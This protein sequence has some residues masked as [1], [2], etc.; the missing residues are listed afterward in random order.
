MKQLFVFFFVFKSVILFT[1]S[2]QPKTEGVIVS[3]N[4]LNLARWTHRYT[5]ERNQ[6]IVN[7]K[8][9]KTDDYLTVIETGND[10]DFYQ[11]CLK[12]PEVKAASLN[13]IL[14]NRIKPNDQRLN[15]LYHH[16]V[17]RSFEAWDITTGGQNHDKKDIVIGIV[18]DGFVT[19]HED[20]K[21]NLYANP[22][23]IAGDGKDN[24]GNGYT[25]DFNGWNQRTG[26]G[27]HDIMSHGTNILGVLGAKGN[28]GKGIVGMN[29]DTKLLPVT[30]N[31]RVSDIIECYNY[32]LAEKKL[33]NATQG[34]KGSNI[35]VVTYSGGLPNAFAKDHPIWCG[36]YDKLGLEG[37]LSVASTTN[38][39]VNVEEDGDM[40]S[41]CTSPYLLIVNSADKSDQMDKVTG[42]GAVS[43][44]LAAPGES[45]LSTDQKSK[46]LYKTESGTSLSTPMVAGAAALIYSLKCKDF[47]DLVTN[48]RVEAVLAVKQAIIDGVDT[49]ISLAGKTTSGGR[50]NVF[51]AMNNIL[52]KYCG[53]AVAPKGDLE[54]TQ[55]RVFGN[56]VSI[57]YVTPDN[58]EYILKLYDSQGREIH[59]ES[60][61]PPVLGEKVLRVNALLQVDIP[62]IASIFSGKNVASKTF[63]LVKE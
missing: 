51:N 29:W 25:D 36:L 46:N 38:D 12:Q 8:R 39:A 13:Y 56:Q 23:E 59:S 47:N 48:S 20:L 17:I 26:N 32:F 3:T 7:V 54:I 4:D 37:I 24:D 22:D 40:P 19:D 10:L 55:V 11:W 14:E 1:Q 27:V 57:N 62:Y 6:T 45:I 61:V 60:F 43:V 63:Y 34:A 44:D 42:Y 16:N 30:A 41:T 50:L 28:N 52:N 58:G 31:N 53:G 18:D 21:D 49:K 35:V 2:V 9:L 5:Q 33:Y 15:E